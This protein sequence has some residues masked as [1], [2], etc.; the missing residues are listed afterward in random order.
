[1]SIWTKMYEEYFQHL[2]ESMPLRQFWRQPRYHQGVPTK[3]SQKV[4]FNFLRFSQ[5]GVLGH[6]QVAIHVWPFPQEV[7]RLQKINTLHELTFWSKPIC[8]ST[9]EFLHRNKVTGLWA[10]CD[11][12]SPWAKEMFRVNKTQL[13]YFGL[14]WSYWSWPRAVEPGQSLAL[15]LN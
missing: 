9:I 4:K 15:C 2:V 3:E 10:L 11:S 5:T 13:N 12:H 7:I 6:M 1:M 14:T 8:R